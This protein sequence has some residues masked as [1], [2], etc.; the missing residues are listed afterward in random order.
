VATELEPYHQEDGITI[1]HGDCREILPSLSCVRLVVT[2]PPYVFGIASSAQEGKAGGWGD[3]MNSASWY[4]LLLGEFQRLCANQ[5]GAAWVFNSWRSFPVL[6]RAAYEARW[7]IESLLVWD[8][9][10]IGPGG[11]NGL[12]PSYELVALFRCAGF[13]IPNRGIPDIWREQWASAR[14]HGHPAE[15]PAAL[16]ARIIS[17]SGGG[18]VLDP[19]MGSG[20]TLVAAKWLGCNAIG[21]EIDE[22]YCEIAAERLRQSVLD[23][24]VSTPETTEPEQADMLE[25][26]G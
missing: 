17:E 8:K 10:W 23:F 12:R 14:P 9:C 6:A 11:P 3:L 18:V 13:S 19:F 16:M 2:D 24:D 1:Y 4:A 5:Q 7:P 15:K 20:T 21:I 26:A 22:R 25:D